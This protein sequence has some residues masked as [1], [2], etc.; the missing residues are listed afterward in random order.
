MAQRPFA[1]YT[2]QFSSQDGSQQLIQQHRSRM[3]EAYSS[4]AGTAGTKHKRRVTSSGIR[5]SCGSSSTTMPA[6]KCTE[7]AISAPLLQLETAAVT[8]LAVE[9]LHDHANVAVAAVLI[10]MPNQALNFGCVLTKQSVS[11]DI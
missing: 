8:P 6:S 3:F 1:T 2:V 7:E 10:E 9:P 11:S 4:V 5:D